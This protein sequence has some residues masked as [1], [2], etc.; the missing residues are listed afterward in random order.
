[1]MGKLGIYDY[2][3]SI[4]VEALLYLPVSIDVESNF[5]VILEKRLNDFVN[6]LAIPFLN[7]R[8]L[9]EDSIHISYLKTLKDGIITTLKTQKYELLK[10][11]LDDIR[12]MDKAPRKKITSDISLFRSRNGKLLDKEDFYHLPFDKIENKNHCGRFNTKSEVTWYLGESD[13]VCLLE[14]IEPDKIVSTIK[15]NLKEGEEALS[16]IDI[17]AE[18]LYSS[19]DAEFEY[20]IVLFPLVLA[21]YC[22]TNS[23]NNFSAYLLPQFLSRYI[24]EK[25][26]EYNVKGIQYFTVR[27]ERLNP[28]YPT[29][30]NVGLFLEK[31]GTDN[32][33]YD[34]NLMNKFNFGKISYKTN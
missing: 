2:A 24:R 6:E 19:N 1:M 7:K 27:N 22:I 14:T 31:D 10:T 34:M 25:Q 16:L 30:K 18:N 29:Y 33:I 26:K 23:D 17:T 9:L 12:F 15:L 13:E 4:K 3:K 21:C 32:C 8:G 20:E 11:T 5:I 28:M